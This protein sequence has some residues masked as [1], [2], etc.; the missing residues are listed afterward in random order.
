[1]I[2]Q[3]LIISRNVDFYSF[4]IITRLHYNATHEVSLK[5]FSW[6]NFEA[7]R[8]NFFFHWWNFGFA[9]IFELHHIAN[10]LINTRIFQYECVPEGY[11]LFFSRDISNYLK[12]RII[13]W[14]GSQ[15]CN[16]DLTIL[17]FEVMPRSQWIIFISMRLSTAVLQLYCREREWR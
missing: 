11:K 4:Q 17:L 6:T 9:N 12:L 15:R 3:C 1:M 8:A 2:L 7:F 5:N 16:I 14:C 10:K 13:R